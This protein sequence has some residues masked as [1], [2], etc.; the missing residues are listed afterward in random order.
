MTTND[1]ELE[2]F[3]QVLP[4]CDSCFPDEVARHLLERGGFTTEDT[5]LIRL[6]AFVLE[7]FVLDIARTSFAHTRSRMESASSDMVVLSVGDVE[8]AM[9]EHK[10]NVKKLKYIADNPG[11]GN[12]V[13]LKLR[14]RPKKYRPTN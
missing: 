6:S 4:L 3:L 11:S 13:P 9:N 5:A 2:R 7:K 8:N 1:S 10:M 14:L 12:P